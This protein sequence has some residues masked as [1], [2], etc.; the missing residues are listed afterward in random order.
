[1]EVI[2]KERYVLECS[3]EYGDIHVYAKWDGCCNIYRYYNGYTYRDENVPE[4]EVDYIHI[5]DL[6]EFIKFLT[7]IADKAEQIENFEGYEKLN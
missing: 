5:C 1:M 3:N 6:R 4:D 2:K 7:D